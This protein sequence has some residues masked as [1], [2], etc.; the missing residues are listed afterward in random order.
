MGRTRSKRGAN[1][2]QMDVFVAGFLLW[3]EEFVLRRVPAADLSLRAAQVLRQ[4][5][6][7]VSVLPCAC[8][9]T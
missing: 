4:L 1:L 8:A 2:L 6:A 7:A 3:S 9:Q 5:S